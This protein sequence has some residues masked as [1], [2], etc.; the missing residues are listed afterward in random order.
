MLCN[1]T[2]MEEQVIQLLQAGNRPKSHRS[3]IGYILCFS[4]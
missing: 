1:F 2:K 4:A 3:E